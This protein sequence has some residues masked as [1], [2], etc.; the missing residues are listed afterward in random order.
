VDSSSDPNAC[1]AGC[2]LCAV[3]ANGTPKCINGVCGVTCNPGFAECSPGQCLDTQ[4]SS[5][6]CGACGRKCSGQNTTGGCSGG[7]CSLSCNSGFGDCNN[8]R[9]TAGGDGCE[10]NLNT[11]SDCGGCGRACSTTEVVT[12]DCQ[13]GFCTSSCKAPYANCLKPAAPT[14]DDG[15]ECNGTCAGSACIPLSSGGTGGVT[16]GGAGGTGGIGA[17]GGGGTGGGGA[18]G[19]GATGGGGAG[20]SSGAGG[21]GGVGGPGAG[22]AGLA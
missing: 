12:L 20:G 13:A 14:A 10:I 22:G 19:V 17:A 1:G 3:P 2:V 21:G 16:V 4:S 8:N 15:C 7:V 9:N 11:T 18:G 6:H 5:I